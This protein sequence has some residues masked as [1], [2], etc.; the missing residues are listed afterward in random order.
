MHGYMQL[1]F[2]EKIQGKG[3][4]VEIIVFEQIEMEQDWFFLIG[5]KRKDK[6]REKKEKKRKALIQPQYQR[7]HVM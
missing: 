1:N 2:Q 4:R 6:E 3:K 5:N 7:R